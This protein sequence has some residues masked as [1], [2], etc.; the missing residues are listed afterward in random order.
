[1][2]I[3]R[4]L[5][6]LFFLISLRSFAQ[7]STINS[8]RDF[9]D[10]VKHK[11]KPQSGKRGR[12]YKNTTFAVLPIPYDKSQ[13]GAL[14]TTFVT[15]FYLGDPD[16][17]NISN[18]FFAPYFTWSK[19]YVLPIRLF[20]YTNKNKYNLGG[21]Y[22]VMIYP[23][24]VFALGKYQSDD[25]QSILHYNQ[26]RM[27]QFINKKVANNFYLGGGFQFD[28]YFNIWEEKKTIDSSDYSKYMNEAPKAY[29]SHGLAL[30]V[31]FDSRRNNLNPQA[32]FFSRSRIRANKTWLGSEVNWSSF[33][34]EMRKYFAFSKQHQRVLALW[35]LYWTS[36]QGKPHFLDLP[37]IGW[38]INGAT[39]RGIRR[40]RYRSN[41]L[42]YFEAEYRTDIT[43]NGLWGA[44]VF[45]NVTS[46]SNFNT[47]QFQYWYPSVGA[48]LRLKWNKY[49]NANLT[50]DIGFSK[51]N[52]AWDVGIYERF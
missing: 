16:S 28:R 27:Y 26:L 13:G 4:F 49:S 10:V 3:S 37:S 30:E 41:A 43:H 34:T 20:V 18:V 14:V 29:N 40:N 22:R 42:A 1:M 24:K 50:L 25:E 39:G 35:G 2:V 15:S 6:L 7:D 32:G 11:M 44:V 12:R 8:Q 33:Y 46:P 19:Q 47:Q 51:K 45:A 36:L 9:I 5:F 48:G 21:D 17:T 23:Q 52:W 38:D 31:M